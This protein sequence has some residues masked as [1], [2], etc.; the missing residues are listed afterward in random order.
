MTKPQIENLLSAVD[1]SRILNCSKR[2]IIRY[3]NS[4]KI[5]ASVRLAGSIK[6]KSSDISLFLECNCDMQQFE[7]MKQT[8][9]EVND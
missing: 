8:R 9:S 1:V 6:W 2:S 7:A 5:P 4:Q 3:A